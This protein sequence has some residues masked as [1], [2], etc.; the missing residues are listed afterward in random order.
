MQTCLGRHLLAV[1][2]L[3]LSLG[4]ASNLPMLGGGPI[5][6]GA[7]AAPGKAPKF[8]GRPKGGSEDRVSREYKVRKPSLESQANGG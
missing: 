7:P 1:R 8:G 4:H 2:F 3:S 5:P 6:G